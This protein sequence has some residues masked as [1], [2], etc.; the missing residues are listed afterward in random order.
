MSAEAANTRPLP[1]L[2]TSREVAELFRRSTRT[3]RAWVQ[4]GRLKPVRIGR[5][6]WFDRRDVERLAGLGGTDEIL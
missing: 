3:L 5:S 2:L 1:E 6:I 4:A